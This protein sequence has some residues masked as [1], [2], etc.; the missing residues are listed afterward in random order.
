MC[1]E[2]S[3]WWYVRGWCELDVQS[4][5]SKCSGALGNM[6]WTMFQHKNGFSKCDYEIGLSPG[7]SDGE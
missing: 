7:R 5:V 2:K 6:V 3:E 4:N 1:N